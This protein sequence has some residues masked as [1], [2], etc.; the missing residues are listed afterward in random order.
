MNQML[1]YSVAINNKMSAFTL[2][3]GLLLYKK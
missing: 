3:K 1:V 2:D